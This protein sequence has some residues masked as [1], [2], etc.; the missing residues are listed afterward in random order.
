MSCW[1]CSKVE[2][3]KAPDLGE[4]WS[5]CPACDATYI[6]VPIIAPSPIVTKLFRDGAG[7]KH[8]TPRKSRRKAKDA[9]GNS[10]VS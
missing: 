10:S 3:V 4:G 1:Y 9:T 8:F 7:E 6:H 5:R 2:M